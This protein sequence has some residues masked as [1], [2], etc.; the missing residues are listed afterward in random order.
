MHKTTSE[1]VQIDIVLAIYKRAEGVR[2]KRATGGMWRLQE[3][4]LPDRLLWAGFREEEY[5][6]HLHQH[7]G[8]G[9]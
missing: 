5:R 6:S 9:Q 1:C 7:C 4:K 8:Q 2:V 3:G